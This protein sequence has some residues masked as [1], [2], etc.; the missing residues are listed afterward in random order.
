[1]PLEE[2]N[3]VPKPRDARVTVTVAVIV[4]VAVACLSPPA[5]AQDAEVTEG[6]VGWWRFDGL[7]D[8]KVPEL[9]GNGNPA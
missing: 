4:A 8:G 3:E 6:L 1:M 5:A 2:A 9:T 7:V